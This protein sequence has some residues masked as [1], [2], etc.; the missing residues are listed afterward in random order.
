MKALGWVCRRD[1]TLGAGDG[2][3]SAA[4]AAVY[5]WKEHAHP[6]GEG[7]AVWEEN[8]ENFVVLEETL[9]NFVVLTQHHAYSPVPG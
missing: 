7:A 6:H 3:E 1:R 2:W 4:P 5:S 9:E 8:L